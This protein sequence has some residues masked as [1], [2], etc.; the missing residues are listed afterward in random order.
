MVNA[1]WYKRNDDLHRNVGILTVKEEIKQLFDKY[2][3]R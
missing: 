2:E 3:V 1:P